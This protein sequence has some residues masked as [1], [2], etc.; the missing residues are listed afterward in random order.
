MVK[1]HCVIIF[2]TI[3]QGEVYNSRFV[4]IQGHVVLSCVKASR[5]LVHWFL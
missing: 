1:S 5:R 2:L 3:T 4:R